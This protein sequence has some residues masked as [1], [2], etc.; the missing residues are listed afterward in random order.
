MVVLRM[1]KLNEDVRRQKM[2]YK[3]EYTEKPTQF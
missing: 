3:N 1:L 2:F